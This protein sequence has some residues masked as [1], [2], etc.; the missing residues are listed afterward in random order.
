MGLENVRQP[1]V[2]SAL[3][4]AER[5][6]EELASYVQGSVLF[7]QPGRGAHITWSGAGVGERAGV[8]VNPQDQQG[9]LVGSEPD[10]VVLNRFY[11]QRRGCAGVL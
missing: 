10:V 6:I 7:Q 8:F 9:G 5:I 4:V 3:A 1:V 2:Q 11:H